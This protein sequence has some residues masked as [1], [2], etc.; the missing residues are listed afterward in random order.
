MGICIER[1][2]Q[3]KTKQSESMAETVFMNST[4]RVTPSQAKRAMA[5]GYNEEDYSNGH[6]Q[7]YYKYNF[8]AIEPSQDY[9]RKHQGLPPSASFIS[10]YEAGVLERQEQDAREAKRI[11]R[12]AKHGGR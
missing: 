2:I 11:A 3:N 1:K 7:A 5:E 8:H 6:D 10:G 4:T 9:I 12:G